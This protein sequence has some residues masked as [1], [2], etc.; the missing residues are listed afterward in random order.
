MLVPLCD[1]Q[2]GEDIAE[3]FVLPPR[4]FHY[5]IQGESIQVTSPHKRKPSNRQLV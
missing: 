3:D 2:L 1:M 4:S 5:L